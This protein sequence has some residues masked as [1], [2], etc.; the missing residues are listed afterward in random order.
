MFHPSLKATD[1]MK[2]QEEE[3]NNIIK[4]EDCPYDV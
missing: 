3:H 1:Y 4:E 2:E